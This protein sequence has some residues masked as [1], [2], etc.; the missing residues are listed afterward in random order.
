MTRIRDGYVNIQPESPRP[1][2]YAE[3]D[4]IWVLWNATNPHPYSTYA[5]AV[6]KLAARLGLQVINPALGERESDLLS[7]ESDEV[8]SLSEL[9]DFGVLGPCFQVCR[10][11]GSMRHVPDGF[12]Q[13]LSSAQHSD[14]SSSVGDVR[15]PQPTEE[16]APQTRTSKDE[17]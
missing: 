14:S 15:T 3:A 5:R 17:F 2:G 8:H 7:T 9:P 10:N 13:G 4:A 6:S 12:L 16:E 11:C 1:R